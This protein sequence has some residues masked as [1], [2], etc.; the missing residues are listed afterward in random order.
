[1]KKNITGVGRIIRGIIGVIIIGAGWYYH[2][3]WGAI[4]IIPLFEGIFSW[5]AVRHFC[6]NCGT[7]NGK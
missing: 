6:G 2:S 3:W 7:V 4:G 1:M 5:C